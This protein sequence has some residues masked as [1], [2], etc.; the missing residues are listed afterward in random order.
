MSNLPLLREI[1]GD[2]IEIEVIYGDALEYLRGIEDG[3]LDLAFIDIEKGSY[4][5]ALRLLRKKLRK[6]G[7]AIFH[8]AIS[9]KPFHP[10]SYGPEASMRV[11]LWVGITQGW[12]MQMMQRGGESPA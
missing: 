9:P 3:S 6:G 2:G 11:E 8:N 1:A 7:I 5:Q 10:H 4:P 12:W